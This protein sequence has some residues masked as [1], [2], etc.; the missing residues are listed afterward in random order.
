M[1]RPAFGARGSLNVSMGFSERIEN[2]RKFLEENPRIACA[3]GVVGTA[4]SARIRMLHE[5][6]EKEAR[7]LLMA[8]FD[9]V[10]GEPGRHP[11]EVR[12]EDVDATR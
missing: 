10:S 7:R 9:G 5:E 3:Y 6:N 2:L 12:A 11:Y 1:S 8:K 4:Y